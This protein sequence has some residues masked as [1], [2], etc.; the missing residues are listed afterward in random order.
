MNF[1]KTKNGTELPLIELQG[2]PYLQVAH[3]I[4]WFREEHPDWVLKSE[5]EHLDDK[6]VRMRGEVYDETGKLRA[7]A[8]KTGSM[9]NP[10]FPM[11]EKVETGSIGRALAMIGYGTQFAPDMDEGEDLADAPIEI[12]KKNAFKES[13]LD[14]VRREVI[15]LAKNLKLKPDSVKELIQ[16]KFNLPDSNNL[17]FDQWKEL[18]GFIE[19]SAGGS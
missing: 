4:V 7:M 15:Q 9:V 1:I 18:G 12:P 10:R 5:I 6:T 8:R 17:T 13:E 3:R 2:K 11:I 19:L 14:K 16:S